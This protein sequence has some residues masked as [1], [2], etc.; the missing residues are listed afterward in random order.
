MKIL[1]SLLPASRG[2]AW[3]LLDRWGGSSSLREPV[4]RGGEIPAPA[5]KAAPFLGLYPSGIMQEARGAMKISG[6][7]AVSHKPALC[8][9]FPRE[10][11]YPFT[12]SIWRPHTHYLLKGVL[13]MF[14]A[15]SKSQVEFMLFNKV[16]NISETIFHR[17]QGIKGQGYLQSESESCSVM[18][19]S[20]WPHRLYSPW[21][22]PGQNIGAGS[23][24]LLQGD[25]PN[26]GIEPR[27]P[28]L[29][30]DSLPAEPQGK[31]KLV[32]M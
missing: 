13:G 32:G 31:P 1:R 18:S 9:V 29:Q 23:L 22:S 11:E 5:T 14:S 7:Q 20:L 28:A 2:W 16:E 21:N 24:S 26:P 8:P 6:W 17:L 12:V 27:S 4:C 30:E 10:G 19:D 25:L 15:S 3:G